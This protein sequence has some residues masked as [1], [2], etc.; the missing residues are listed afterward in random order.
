MCLGYVRHVD[1]TIQKTYQEEEV[2]VPLQVVIRNKPQ[3][4]GAAAVTGADVD[5]TPD[6]PKLHVGQKVRCADCCWRACGLR[7]WAW[8]P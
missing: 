2:Q 6:F 3:H 1:G 7:S 8:A 4:A 5:D